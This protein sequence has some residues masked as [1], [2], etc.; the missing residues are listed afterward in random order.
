VRRGAGRPRAALRRRRGGGGEGISSRTLTAVRL[1]DQRLD[2]ASGRLRRETAAALDAGSR[3]LAAA[4]RISRLDRPGPCARPSTRSTWRRPT[5]GARPGCR[6]GTR[7]SIT[8]RADGTLVRSIS[9]LAPGD[10]LVTTV[11]TAR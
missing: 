2:Y 9:A 10:D 3:R 8:R 1:A 6:A 4:S 11:A 7:W 5:A